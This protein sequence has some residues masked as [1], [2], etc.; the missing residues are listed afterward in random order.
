M[1]DW[2]ARLHATLTLATST[3]PLLLPATG[4]SRDRTIPGKR[5]RLARRTR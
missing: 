5:R 1:T 4:P 2:L 3:V